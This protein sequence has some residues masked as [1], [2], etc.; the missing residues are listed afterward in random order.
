MNKQPSFTC[1]R[2]NTPSFLATHDRII[3]RKFQYVPW[4]FPSLS[5]ELPLFGSP[6]GS[7]VI[8]NCRENLLKVHWSLLSSQLRGIESIN[9][10]FQYI[11]D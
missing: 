3:Y 7:V 8:S 11:W 9:N 1:I 10:A 6:L 4:V 5:Y 2:G